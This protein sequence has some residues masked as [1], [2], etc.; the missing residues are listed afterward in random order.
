MINW[1]LWWHPQARWQ[2][3]LYS[4]WQQLLMLFLIRRFNECTSWQWLSCDRYMG[5]P[6]SLSLSLLPVLLYSA[7]LSHSS[8]RLLSWAPCSYRC[9][10]AVKLGWSWVCWL[11]RSEDSSQSLAFWELLHACDLLAR[12]LS[13]GWVGNWVNC[14]S[15][16]WW[17]Y[18]ST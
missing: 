13:S 16:V 4:C 11:P 3:C 15:L 6:S 12:R 18:L 5:P 1:L 2:V 10:T 17:H 8:Q 9:C 7:L 14:C